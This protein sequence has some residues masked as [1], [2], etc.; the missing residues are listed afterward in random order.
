ML[1]RQ[2]VEAN[3]KVVIAGMVLFA[4]VAMLLMAEGAM[5]QAPG[6]GATPTAGPPGGS[7]PL[8]WFDWLYRNYEKL[9]LL[10]LGGLGVFFWQRLWPTLLKAGA[11]TFEWGT[12][13]LGLG[14]YRRF[15]RKY[16]DWLAKEH[17]YLG[18][19]PSPVIKERREHGEDTLRRRPGQ[20]APG[21]EHHHERHRCQQSHR[22]ADPI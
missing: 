10:I 6:P 18:A 2:Q 12:A 13:R 3:M 11:N 8:A 4:V 7:S 22:E 20:S 17:S 1:G 15:E 9:V 16:L 21:I 19:I 5:A 14:A